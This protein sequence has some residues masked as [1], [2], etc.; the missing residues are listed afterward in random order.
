MLYHLF[1]PLRLESEVLGFLNVL[2]YIPFRALL[3]TVSALILGFILGPWFIHKMKAKNMGEVIRSDGPKRHFEKRGTPT[4]GG[5]VILIAVVVST[6]LWSDLTN[7]FIWLVILITLGYGIIG[8]ID[9]WRKF[10]QRNSEGLR[11]SSK[12]ALQFIL[13]IGVIGFLF[14]GHIPGEWQEI[15]WR[16]SLPFIAFEKHPFSLPAFIYIPFAVLIVVGMSNSVNL[17]DGLDGLAIGPAIIAAGTYTIWAYLS[18]AKIG[19]F[20]IAHYLDIPSIQ[21]VAELMI[22]G[23]AIVGAGVGFLWYNTYPA[24]VFMGDVGSLSLGGALGILAVLTKTEL[25]SFILCGIFVLETISVITQVISYKLTGQR[26]FRMAPLHHHFELKG[27]AEPKII[28]R[29]WIIAIMLALFS[30]ASL[31]LR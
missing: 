11:A 24:Q 25:L 21:A 6:L 29:F 28:V 15:K 14:L 7:I 2:R 22:F 16:I 12:L 8:F 10:R 13:A 20:N 26:I 27:W 30:L 31:K 18:G 5:C 17:T 1:Y 23:G 3:A 9:D 19:G 4:M